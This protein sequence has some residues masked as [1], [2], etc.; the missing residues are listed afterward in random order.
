MTKLKSL[1]TELLIVAGFLVLPLL[2]FGAVSLGGRTMLPVDNLYQWAPWASAASELEAEIP[3]NGLLSD[4]ILENYAWKRFINNSISEGVIPLWNPHIFAGTP[5]LAT[6]QHSAY[7]PFSLLFI[8]LPLTMAYGWFTISQL[9]L[10]GTLAYI[11]ARVL[12]QRP[13]GAAVAGL[14]YQGCGFLLVSAAVFPM[15]L[16]AAV[17]LPLLLAAVEKVIHH[18][19]LAGSGRWILPWA[20][21]GTVALGCQ[22]LAGH[23]EITYYTL[24][25]M[26]FFAA[27]RLVAAAWKQAGD[28]PG[29]WF[30]PSLLRPAGWLLGMVAVGLMLGAVQFVPFVEV[31]QANFREG[32]ASLQEIRGWAFPVRRVVTLAVP[33][34]FG[35]PADHNYRDL[36]NGQIVPFTTNYYGELNPHGAYTSNW[37]IKNYVEGGIYLGILPL[38]LAGLGIWSAVRWFKERRSV[39]AFFSTLSLLSLSF[40]FGTPLY[41]L[42]YYGLPGINQLHSPFRWVFPLSMSVAVLAGSGMDYLAANREELARRPGNVVRSLLTLRSA[43]WSPTGVLAGLSFWA[44]LLLLALLLLSRAFFAQIEPLVNRLFLALAQA[45]DAFPDGR[46][47]YSYEFWQLLFLGLMLVASGVVLRLSVGDPRRRPTWPWLA[48]I[49][50]GLDLFVVGYG[51]RAAVKPELLDYQPELVEWL[52]QQP[53]LWR[54]T[55]FAPHGDK[56][57]NANTPWHDDLQDVRGYDSVILKQYTDY[58][59]A[60]Q[61]QNELQFNRIQ[62][63]ASWE[64]LNSPLL[65]L[66]G[67]RYIITAE[68]VELPKLREVW[69]GEGLRVYENL[70]AVPRAYTIPFSATVVVDDALEG[71]RRQDPRQFVFVETADWPHPLPATTAAQELAP[72]EVTAYGSIEVAVQAAVEEPSWL[73]L[74]DTYFQGWDVFVQPLLPADGETGGESQAQLVRVN[75]N[76]RGVQLEPGQWQVRFR[77]S[78]LSFKLGGLASFMAG[79]VLLFAAAVWAWRQFYRPQGE[80]TNTR[81]IAKNSLA[82]MAL[83][84]FNRAIDFAFAA[85]YLRLLGPA[86]SGSYATA[87]IIAGWYEIIANFGLNTLVIREVARDKSQASRYLLNTTILRLGIGIV[88]TLPVVVYL[89]GIRLAGNPLDVQTT[90]AIVLLMVGMVF[91]GMGQ[92]LA[93]LYYAY[94]SAEF[95][96]AITTITTILKVAFGVLALL[97]G[98]SFVGLAAV[99]IIVNVITLLI[100]VIAAFRH[101]RLP[102]PWQVDWPLQRRMVG[103]SYPLML[104]HLLAVIF[105]QIDIPLLRQFNGEAV[106]GWYNSAYKWVNAFN[107]IPSFFTF[108]LF[109]VI[110]RQVHSSLPDARRTFRMSIKLMVLLALPLAAVTTLLAPILIGLLGGREF[111]PHGAIA[112]QLIIWSIPIGWMNSVTN[113][114]LISLGVERKLT[115]AFIIGVSF[116]IILNLIFLP[117]FSYLAASV[118]TIMS[119]VVLLLLFARYLKP[120]M[121]DVRWLNLLIRPLVVTAVMLGAM[122]L[123]SQ[124]N[125]LVGLVLGVSVYPLGL[126]LLRAFGDEERFIL[127]SLLPGRMAK[128]LPQRLTATKEE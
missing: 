125:M 82:P 87:I 95:P 94:E 71:M 75:G 76:F 45:P 47:F 62:P 127:S 42:L 116:N 65:D 41:A 107:V 113:Y 74:N 118:T 86:N 79:I 20:S 27:W 98:Y 5:F 73:I 59:A 106:V 70:A 30:V 25:V 34:F 114:V 13:A 12:G 6:G 15:I 22:V 39:T 124:I 18:A 91:S 10:A 7:Y 64:S 38:L 35:N 123:G 44:G 21:L 36:F 117:R 17:W 16:A 66:L 37:G 101:F 83:N 128:R 61:P 3:H 119:E 52:K 23:I 24:L 80:L 104:N 26:A 32:S 55:T 112:L 19:S 11:L 102:G 72:A 105:F 58:M 51:F 28:Q 126:W 49:V 29:R 60:I 110:S 84:L 97:M 89:V 50:I 77:Y 14:V 1:R 40:I 111:L 53:G 121:P 56:P 46:A 99:S 48:V 100:L 92:G 78:P 33:D 90:L 85:F 115:G 8:I 2:L 4:L 88:A 69:Q 54:L 43:T 31:G 68:T 109:P 103:L 108:A 122:V 9:W 63:I 57:L 67:V 93:G 120:V 81:S 96:A